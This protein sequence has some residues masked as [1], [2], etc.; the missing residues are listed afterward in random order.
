MNKIDIGA[1]RP[2][3]LDQQR[4]QETSQEKTTAPVVEK[5]MGTDN[6][7]SYDDLL[8]GSDDMAMLLAQF[9]RRA[10]ADK[11]NSKVDPFERILEEQ[12]E[13]K[14]DQLLVIARSAELSPGVF[15]VYARAMFPDDSDLVLVLR[16]MIRRR[17]LEKADTSMLEEVLQQIWDGSNQKQCKA[18]VN[19]GL[20]TRIFSKKLAVSAW[21][22]RDSYRQFLE[23]QGSELDEYGNWVTDYGNE[24]RTIVGEFIQT[25]LLHDIQSHDPS[26]SLQEFGNLLNRVVNLKKIQASDM[27]FQ[28]IFLRAGTPVPDNELLTCWFD[29]L[30]RP[31]E[32]QQEIERYKLANL[33]KRLGLTPSKLQQTLLRAIQQIDNDLFFDDAVKHILIESLLNLDLSK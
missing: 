21:A 30:Q 3:H 26:C 33:V 14:V 27:T 28:Q 22:L 8:M 7:L 18:G 4:T 29:C 1:P 16:E 6:Q 23:S 15:L 17:K 10:M 20:K 11:N 13:P 25:A 19:V 24:R 2:Q 31:F 32:I 9:R 12:S 5:T